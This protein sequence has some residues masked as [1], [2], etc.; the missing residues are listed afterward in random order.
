[1]HSREDVT[2]VTQHVDRLHQHALLPSL[3]SPEDGIL[4]LHGNLLRSRCSPC[5][6]VLGVCDESEPS[7]P[8]PLPRCPTCAELIRPDVVWF[9]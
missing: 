6:W 8:G 7:D 2:L 3:G 4:D 1:M 9:R 5:D